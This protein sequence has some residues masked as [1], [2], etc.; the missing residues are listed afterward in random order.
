[1]FVDP[2]EPCPPDLQPGAAFTVGYLV[3]DIRRHQVALWRNPRRKDGV[4]SDF[5]YTRDGLSRALVL[6]SEF[7]HGGVLVNFYR[8]QQQV[9]DDFAL[10][11]RTVTNRASGHY[12]LKRQ[13]PGK[14][15]WKSLVALTKR[16]F[17]SKTL[18]QW[19]ILGARLSELVR[20][21]NTD[22]LI[23]HVKSVRRAA[24]DAQANLSTQDLKWLL[25]HLDCYES[26]AAELGTDLLG[27]LIGPLNLWSTTM[28]QR[29][30]VREQK[31]PVLSINFE[32]RVIILH[33]T[34]ISFDQF[35]S[36]H[37]RILY[38]LAQ[39]PSQH[40]KY[41]KLEAFIGTAAESLIEI[42]SRLRKPLKPAVDEYFNTIKLPPTD[43]AKQTYITCLRKR[44][45]NSADG[46]KK[47]NPY[48]LALTKDQVNVTGTPPEEWCSDIDLL[49]R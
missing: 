34:S 28:V 27:C 7:I 24:L 2:Q 38:A 20:E 4:L 9:F 23:E 12:T 6:L 18:H 15:S 47:M 45:H 29:L 35:Q 41:D 49:G 21:R 48:C 31:G 26:D 32:S 42:V 1:M 10:I 40:I 17:V 37:L 46:Y 30:Y 16:L 25:S 5:G 8:Q 44:V 14:N 33:N 39:H 19:A 22:N 11:D 3:S 43:A 13:V 36:M